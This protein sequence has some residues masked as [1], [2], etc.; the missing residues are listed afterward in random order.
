MKIIQSTSQLS[1]GH[2]V[3]LIIVISDR[4]VGRSLSLTLRHASPTP[5]RVSV[6]EEL[7]DYKFNSQTQIGI[8]R[9]RERKA[10]I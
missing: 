5:E 1:T 4:C 9:E 3:Q 2:S 7:L 8:D 6:V 10:I